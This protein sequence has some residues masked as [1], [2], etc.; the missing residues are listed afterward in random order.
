MSEPKKQL[1][2]V[3]FSA[4]FAVS[5]LLGV[6]SSVP[7]FREF[8]R[9]AVIKNSY[10]V[11]A[12]AEAHLNSVGER[13]IVL[14]VQT[15]DSLALEIFLAD[16]K[17]ERA[18]FLKRIILPERR[19]GYFNFRGNAANLVMA[20]VDGDQILDIIA[21]TFDDN[22]MPRLNVFKYIPDTKDFIKMG[23]DSISL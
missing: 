13:I 14:K 7:S 18:S 11:L 16:E 10:R 21:P 15:A 3:L 19:D 23:P 20:D 17:A 6:L 8:I 4:L 1:F 5:L 9:Q 22:L 2:P 12:K